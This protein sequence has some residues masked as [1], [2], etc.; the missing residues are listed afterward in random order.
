MSL[1]LPLVEKASR[2]AREIQQL[3]HYKWRWT[4]FHV[5][6]AHHLPCFVKSV[7]VDYRQRQ[8]TN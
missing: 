8:I 4:Q 3:R 1:P 6:L 5:A 2:S 7:I